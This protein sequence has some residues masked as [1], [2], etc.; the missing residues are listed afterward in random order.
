MTGKTICSSPSKTS[1]GL[2]DDAY[3]IIEDPPNIPKVPLIPVAM[4]PMPSESPV[5]NFDPSEEFFNNSSHCSD[6]KQRQFSK[7]EIK[8]ISLPL[9][10]VINQNVRKAL[11]FDMDNCLY[12]ESS[13][14]SECMKQ[15]ILSFC[16]DVHNMTEEEAMFLGN[17]YLTDYGLSIKGLLLH[18]PGTDPSHYD[19]FVDGGI[20]IEKLLAKH[21]PNRI[22]DLFNHLRSAGFENIWI[23]TNAGAAHALR[24][25]GFL[26]DSRFGP[27]NSLSESEKKGYF[28]G[29]M[30]CDYKQPDFICK[31]HKKVF[32][33]AGKIANIPPESYCVLIDDSL[34]NIL[35]AINAGWKAVLVSESAPSDHVFLENGGKYMSFTEFSVNSSTKA[36]IRENNFFIVI[37]VIYDIERVINFV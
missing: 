4:Y 5:T 28:D 19:R 22:K 27:N 16:A 3:L 14:I 34:V 18:H 17:K 9:A 36:Q 23:L 11:F 37:R 12:P 26:F 7:H 6:D 13:G 1:I 21:S 30:Y 33:S 25:L 29:I 8:P 32:H 10:S 24:T 31:P 35:G 15:R 2:P 20:D